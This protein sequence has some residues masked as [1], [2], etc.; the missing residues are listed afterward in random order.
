MGVG[1]SSSSKLEKDFGMDFPES[2]RFFGLENFGNTC[3]CNSVLQ[4]LYFCKP[5]RRHVLEYYGEHVKTIRTPSD[6]GNMMT[7]LSELFFE[8][9]TQ[10]SKTGRL[11]PKKFVTKLRKENELF[12][13]YMHQDAHE[14]LNFLLNNT[15]ESLQKERKEYLKYVEEHGEIQVVRTEPKPA[16]SQP[17]PQPLS[18]NPKPTSLPSISKTS[19]V[20]IDSVYSL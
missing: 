8:M 20:L 1:P 14:F 12:R 13:G 17:I 10:K 11:S 18:M 3:Y 4:A 6:E 7:V 15:A 16:E 9:N 5:F 2:E 19:S